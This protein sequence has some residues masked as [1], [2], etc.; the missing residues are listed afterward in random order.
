MPK[1]ADTVPAYVKTITVC[2]HDDGGLRYARE[3]ELLL[4]DRGFDDVRFDDGEAP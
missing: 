1:L 4:T 3:L 2:A